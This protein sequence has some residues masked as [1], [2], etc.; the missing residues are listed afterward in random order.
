[1]MRFRIIKEAIENILSE[2]SAGRYR[3]IGHQ[4][5]TVDAGDNVDNDRSI[6]V[7]YQSGD[8]AISQNLVGPHDHM[9][10]FRVEMNVAKGAE[11]NLSGVDETNSQAEIAAAISTFQNASALADSSF[12]ELFDHLFQ[13][14]MSPIYLDFGLEKT[15][16]NPDG[17]FVSSRRLVDFKKEGPMSWGEYVM[18]S[19]SFMIECKTT[20]Y[21]VGEVGTSL[22]TLSTQIDIVD[23]DVEKTGVE[24]AME[25]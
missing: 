11:G 17:F 19:G 16:E 2:N 21:V 3:V 5:R 6:Q 12:D 15:D 1:M 22:L 9:M 13:I 25:E 10:R 24:V 14:I 20:E 8:F 23:D 18:V 4:E 7:F